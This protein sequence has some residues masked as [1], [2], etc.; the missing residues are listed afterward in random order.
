MYKSF[1]FCRKV[2][3]E[4]QFIDTKLFFFS[5]RNL[6]VFVR[7]RTKKKSN[8]HQESQPD[9]EEANK[10]ISR[11]AS[12]SQRTLVLVIVITT[13]TQT[14]SGETNE[15]SCLFTSMGMFIIDEIHFPKESGKQS[16]Y[17]VIGGGGCYGALGSR[18]ISGPS[19]SK[20]V[21]WII[22]KG[23]DFP[24]EVED[25]LQKWNTGAVWRNT[26]ERLTTRGWN[27]YG[28]RDFRGE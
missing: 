13:M 5:Q 3:L 8:S 15:E 19:Q 21:G 4:N 24:V 27:M 16:C 2:F 25:Y 28:E 10:L 6:I 26:P 14:Q 20:K 12:R 17:N 18:I 9:S 23:S 1:Q 22:D 7:A 11:L